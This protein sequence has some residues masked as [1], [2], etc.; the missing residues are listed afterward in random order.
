MERAA[1]QFVEPFGQRGLR[2]AEHIFFPEHQP[3]HCGA[4]FLIDAAAFQL[5][6]KASNVL[7][8]YKVIH[9]G[10]SIGSVAPS[11]KP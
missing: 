4:R 8:G 2:P 10:H 3:Q 5:P 9:R 6:T 1:F 7:V 11:V